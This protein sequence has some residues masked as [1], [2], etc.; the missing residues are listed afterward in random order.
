METESPCSSQSQTLWL[1]KSTLGMLAFLLPT[2]VTMWLMVEFIFAVVFYRVWLPRFQKLRPPEDYRDYARDRRKLLIRILHRLETNCRATNTPL[3]PTIQA[4]VR[5]WFHP[6][7]L[8]HQSSGMKATTAIRREERNR[9]S[10]TPAA[11]DVGTT[12]TTSNAFWPKRGDMDHFFAWAFFGKNFDEL[13]PWM[14]KDMQRMYE[15]IE[16][17]YGLTF[18]VGI[19]PE[20]RPM[21]L[22][23]DPLEPAYRPF[24]V[25]GIFSFIKIMAGLLLRAVGFY[26]GK[27]SGGL[28]YFY[29]PA[30]KM[31]SQNQLGEHEAATGPAE[32]RSKAMLPLIFLHGIAPGGLAFYLPMLF[33]LASDGRPLLFFENPD[34]SFIL[35][36]NPPNERDTVHGVWEAVDRHLDSTQ[37]VS[38]VGHS[39]GSCAVTWLV[40]SAQKARIRQIV[41][42]DPVSILLSEPDVIQN[43]LYQRKALRRKKMPI[44][45]GVVCNEIFTEHYLRRHFSWYNSELWLEDVPERAKILVCLSAEDPIVPAQ[46]VQREVMMRKPEIDMLLW[47]NAGHAHCVTRPRTWRQMQVAMKRQELIILEEDAS[48]PSLTAIPKKDL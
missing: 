23:L 27:T 4:Y 35:G 44:K 22:S 14:I 12:A 3:L 21:R 1:L 17:H 37:E 19:T 28:M 9:F 36:G 47:E 24:F 45:L 48:S 42:V 43:F 7:D 33:F 34:I 5:E 10:N 38:L 6:V 18:A 40:H 2:G 31:Q 46:K 15:T 25:Y 13:E 30:R 41:L 29:R 11:A 16:S 39:F 26:A 20:Y 8:R 32:T